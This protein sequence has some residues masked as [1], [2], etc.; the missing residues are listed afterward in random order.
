MGPCMCGYL[1]CFSCG[2]AQ[3][4]FQCEVCGKW[5]YD[6][7]CDDEQK[8]IAE[9]RRRNDMYADDIEWEREYTDEISKIIK[10]Q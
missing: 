10:E 2:P 9:T 8:C 3:G 5:S 7:G 1:Y 4:N 6:G